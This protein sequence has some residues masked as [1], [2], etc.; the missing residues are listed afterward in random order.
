VGDDWDVGLSSMC[1]FSHLKFVEITEVEGC[2][3][4]LKFL[5]FL[6]KYSMALEEV[7]LFFQSTSD[8]LDKGR[9]LRRFKRN[10]R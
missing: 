5:R 8:L 1:M 3:N 7:N 10:V 9:Q 4:E 6:L 2:D